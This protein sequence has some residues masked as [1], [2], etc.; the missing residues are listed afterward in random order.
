MEAKLVNAPL[1][2]LGE[3]PCW[4]KDAQKLYWVDIIGKAIHILDCRTEELRKIQLDQ[5]VGAVVLHADGGLLAALQHGFFRI[6]LEAEKLE[7]L[8]DPESE[9]E[10]NRFNDGKCDPAGRF[11]AGTMSLV[12]EKQAGA[13]Y[14]LDHDGEIREIT[15]NVT[16]SNGLAWSPDEQTMYYIDT[17]T[18]KVSA[19]DYDKDSGEISNRRT[20]IEVPEKEG[21]PD[22]MC[23]DKEGKLWI[24]HWGG[25][26]VARWDPQTGEKLD[27]IRVPAAQTS[28]C[29]FAGPDMDEMFITTAREGLSDDELADQPQAGGLFKVKLPV[30]GMP[31]TAYQ[32]TTK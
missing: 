4:D 29:A 27:S 19:F 20:V 9:R 28:S 24:A 16:I 15:T 2:M 32:G 21:F 14:C 23:I 12:G 26:Q 3:G 17:P 6:N 5:Y 31:T 30:Q 13:L 10:T 7:A 8:G 1:S 18:C 25:W 11:W 22:G